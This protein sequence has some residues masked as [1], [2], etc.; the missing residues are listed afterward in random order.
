MS[1]FK[2]RSI[3][4]YTLLLIF[5]LS[6]CLAFAAQPPTVAQLAELTPS[7][8]TS[9]DWFGYSLAV[10]ENVVVVGAFD[11][12][13]EQYG[14]VYVYVK[15]ATGWANMTQVAKLTSSDNGQGFGT[16]VAISGNT[17][18]VGAANTSNFARPASSPGAVYVFVEPSAGWTDMTETAKLTA[19]DG[20]AGDALGNSVA[21]SKNIIAAGAFFASDKSG[22]SFAGKA[23]V[24]VRPAN[25]W[26]GNLTQTAELTAS[27]SQLLN[28]MGASIGIS[29]NTVVAGSYGHNNFEGV[30]YVFVAPSSGW[31]NMTQT[32]ELSASDG[33]GSADFGFS[34][35]I[36]V[37]TIVVGAV[38]AL[39][40]KGA[41]YV[42]AKPSSGWTSMTE[43][44]ELHAAN[45]TSGDSFGQSVAIS[46]NTVMIGAPSAN[47]GGHSFQGAAYVF[48]RP[49]GGWSNP[50]HGS[51]LVSSDGQS[52]DGF[53]LSVGIGNL[54][55]VAGAI[56]GVT[57]GVAYVFGP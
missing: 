50:A 24:F 11:M 40:G 56:R 26:A 38:N 22:N 44:A 33:K 3:F 30:A 54:V 39:G 31:T 34:T 48:L 47:A 45:A 53:G 37:E 36:Q 19:S 43:T 27:D 17:I 5:L 12:N 23:Y 42:F 49:R 41:A 10:S 32:A 7:D 16:S 1:G 6:A 14:S 4:A 25:G 20:Q 29:G 15:P 18:V 51:E 35:A 55:F 9:N 57:P 46:G 2:V 52:N 28:Y 21:I 8:S 13:T